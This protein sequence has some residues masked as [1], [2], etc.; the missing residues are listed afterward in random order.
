MSKYKVK[1]CVS[2]GFGGGEIEEVI[3]LVEDYNLDEE[4]AEK[5]INSEKKLE[6]LYEEWLYNNIDIDYSIVESEDEE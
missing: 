2:I 5:I 4:E 1:F 3:D 6:N